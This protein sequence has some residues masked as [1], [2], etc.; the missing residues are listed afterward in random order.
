MP[1]R[2]SLPLILLVLVSLGGCGPDLSKVDL[3][4]VVFE[5]PKVAGSDE[6]Y[7]MPQ[8]GPPLEHQTDPYGRPLP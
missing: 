8:L 2:L 7:Q 6:P 3:G 4:A 1:Y 5:V